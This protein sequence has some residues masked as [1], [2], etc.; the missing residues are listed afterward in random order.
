MQIVF[1]EC[2]ILDNFRFTEMLQSQF[3]FS[4]HL[5]SPNANILH[6]QGA[7]VKTKKLT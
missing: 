3:P 6:E 1:N 4:L 5:A 2:V 7:F